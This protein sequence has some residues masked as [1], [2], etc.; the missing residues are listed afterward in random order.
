MLYGLIWGIIIYGANDGV[1]YGYNHCEMLLM[2]YLYP[3]YDG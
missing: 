3:I 2:G 1:I